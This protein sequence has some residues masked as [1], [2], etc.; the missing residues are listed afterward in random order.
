MRCH[1]A[2]AS[3]NC[4]DAISAVVALFADATDHFLRCLIC[5]HHD[6][7]NSCDPSLAIGNRLPGVQGNINLI[8]Q[9]AKKGVKRFILLTSIGVGDSKDAPPQQVYDVLKPVLIE[10]G[11]AE[12]RLKVRLS[13][14]ICVYI[15]MYVSICVTC[16]CM[17]M[18][19]QRAIVPVCHSLAGAC[20]DVGQQS[21]I[22]ETAN[23]DRAS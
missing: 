21:C 19:S 22:N 3:L 15:Y 1:L 2:L 23:W 20:C 10:K 9:A 17:Y 18:F 8:E 12:E 4:N 11:K 6:C 16:I 13:R 5:R 7:V 14:N